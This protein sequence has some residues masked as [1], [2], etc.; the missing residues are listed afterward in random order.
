[1]SLISLNNIYK[2]FDNDGKQLKVLEDINLSVN[3]KEFI[4]FF[5]PN[6]CGKTTLMNVI[7]KIENQTSGK[8]VLNSNDADFKI[9]YVF[10]NYRDSL[11]TWLSVEENICFPLKIQHISKSERKNKLANLINLFNVNIDLKSKVFNLSGGQAQLV[12]ILRGVITEPNL[13]ILDEPF[14]ALDYQTNLNLY[15]QLIDIWK[16]INV[17]ILFISHEIDEAIYL[18]D[19]V[20]F[21]SNR[22]AN[23]IDILKIEIDRPRS[24][25]IMGSKKFSEYKAKAIKIFKD[26]LK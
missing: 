8:L 17:T 5:G 1:M 2:S 10:Q 16:K 25:D 3:D 26:Q 12:S 13:L 22:P 11:M 4:T 14:S 23:I 24:L 20:V 6:G 18:G 15:E 9:S 7:S 21:L 19:R